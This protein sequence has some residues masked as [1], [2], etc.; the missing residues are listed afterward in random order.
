MALLRLNYDRLIRP[1]VAGVLPTSQYAQFSGFNAL[2]GSSANVPGSRNSG[3]S[4]DIQVPGL[5][6]SVI[7]TTNLGTVAGLSNYLRYDVNTSA[8]PAVGSQAYNQ[9]VNATYG[10]VLNTFGPQLTRSIRTIAS[11]PGYE[12]TASG[13]TVTAGGFI[14][15]YYNVAATP[16][17]YESPLGF[18]PPSQRTGM[19]GIFGQGGGVG[20]E[21]LASM[22]P[23]QYFN[24]QDYL[25]GQKMSTIPT[26]PSPLSRNIGIDTVSSAQASQ[27]L[28]TYVSS[29]P[30]LTVMAF[31][32]KQNQ[33]TT[34]ARP[35]PVST[36][37]TGTLSTDVSAELSRIQSQ[38]QVY[39]AELVK[40]PVAQRAILQPLAQNTVESFVEAPSS[41]LNVKTVKPPTGITSG[42]VSYLAQRGLS[43]EI[44]GNQVVLKATKTSP[45]FRESFSFGP[46]TFTSQRYTSSVFGTSASSGITSTPWSGITVSKRYYI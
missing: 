6:Q 11:A 27:N 9:A 19:T 40:S 16:S 5:K 35:L 14:S 17:L 10:N 36:F 18:V 32:Q 38:T 29:L 24:A 3:A 34:I 44:Q 22:T 8:I 26:I 25:L 43:G 13:Q 28:Q 39:A 2:V 21:R 37:S 15:N 46:S 23:T 1:S 33:T 45:E 7:T 4:R 42:T 31:E 30:S 12:A 20:I 41:S